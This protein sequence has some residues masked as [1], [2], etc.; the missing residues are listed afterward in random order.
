VTPVCQNLPKYTSESAFSGE[1]TTSFLNLVS[2]FGYS[3]VALLDDQFVEQVR[4]L[5]F[6]AQLI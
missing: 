5:S 2:E 6:G 3:K 1:I 4:S